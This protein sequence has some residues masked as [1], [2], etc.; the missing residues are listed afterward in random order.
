MK[1]SATSPSPHRK[2][3]APNFLIRFETYFLLLKRNHG[4]IATMAALLRRLP[5]YTGSP[6]RCLVAIIGGKQDSSPGLVPRG[7]GPLQAAGGVPVAACCH[8]PSRR[9][10]AEA[11]AAVEVDLKHLD[12]EDRGRNINNKCFSLDLHRH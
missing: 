7:G 2:Y 8:T 6:S 9:L 10:H 3:S 1:L 4:G 11:P 12:G 5:R